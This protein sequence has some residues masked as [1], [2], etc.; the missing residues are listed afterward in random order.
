MPFTGAH[1]SIFLPFLKSKRI[2]ATG[3]IA[4]SIAPDF[5][6]FIKMSSG[7]EH[8]HTAAG[9]F[10]FDLPVAF[11]IA[12]IFHQVVKRA[13]SDQLPEFLRSRDVLGRDFEFI[14]YL[15]SHY[16]AFILCAII[17]AASHLIWDGFTHNTWVTQRI[18][19][20][21][22][23]SLRVGK[24][25]YPLFYLLQQLS[26][27]AGTLAVMIY[28]LLIPAKAKQAEKGNLKA[29]WF[30]AWVT[31]GTLAILVLRFTLPESKSNLIIVPLPELGDAVVTLISGFLISLV[32]AT[33]YI[34]K[35]MSSNKSLVDER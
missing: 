5:E 34:N 33:A 24:L 32:V 31:T 9:I 23:I 17:G 6:Y 12:L 4:G 20:Y 22:M 18:P 28:L 3:L 16:F 7:S 1:P 2:S 27:I 11:L 26:T 10:Y 8:S 35:K 29:K 13:L 30:W 15:R 19:V 25:N 14:D 21:Q